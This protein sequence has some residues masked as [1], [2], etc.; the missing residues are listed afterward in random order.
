MLCC[1][2]IVPFVWMEQRFGA[3]E[4]Q[5]KVPGPL[6]PAAAREG[7]SQPGE[8][9]RWDGKVLPTKGSRQQVSSSC[10]T[11]NLF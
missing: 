4:I 7:I 2:G 1:A 6:V 9:E 5:S 3:T 11:P 8:V 10:S